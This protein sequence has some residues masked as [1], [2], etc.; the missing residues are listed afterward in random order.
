MIHCGILSK[1]IPTIY[2][3]APF[4]VVFVS[5]IANKSANLTENVVIFYITIK[6]ITEETKRSNMLS[7]LVKLD[8]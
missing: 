4:Y 2:I 8:F 1:V 6:I 5:L 7:T 3:T